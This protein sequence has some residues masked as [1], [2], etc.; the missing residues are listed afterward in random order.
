[1]KIHEYQGKEILR[2]FGVTV[3]R[4]IPCMSVDE[5]VK[6]AEQLGGP[7]WVVKAQIHAGGRGKGGG[8]KVAKSLEQVREYANQIMGMQLVTHQTGPEGQKVRR[9]LIEEG[10]DIKKELYVSMVTDR[11]SQ[12]VVLMASS[13]G[14]MDIEEV[15]HSHPEKI[16]NVVID[17]SIGLTDK[18]A[19][20]IARKIGVP[21]GSIADARKNLQGLYK[22]YW[23]T[24]ASLAEI[25]PLIL[26]GD[27]K[28]IALDAKFNFD[29]NALFRHPEIV[30]YRDLDEE[31]PAEVEASKFDLAYISLDGNIGCLVNGAGLAMA[32]M[33]T[34]K[35]FGGEP[36][37]FLDVGGGATAEKVTEAFKIMLKNPGLKA[38]LVNIFGGIMRCDVIAEGVI[39]ASKAVSLNVP[40]VVRMKGTNEDIGKK[41]LAESGLPIISA[42]TMEDAAKQVVAAAAGKA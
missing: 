11:V 26:T 28:V 31:D 20:D 6:A 17:P 42:D 13:E 14:G 3:P 16:H 5:A 24:D 25:N 29:S 40:L 19:D 23:E 8:V 2:K 32:T 38:I 30:A 4:G 35:L 7:V 34:I 27:G 9:L 21:E 33:D 41:M 39:T 36:A 10:A 15:A 1:M 18:D 22:A 12:R 37:N